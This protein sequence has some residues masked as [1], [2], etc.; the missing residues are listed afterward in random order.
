MTTAS[1]VITKPEGFCWHASV[2]LPLALRS[3]HG[4]MFSQT[5]YRYCDYVDTRLWYRSEWPAWESVVYRTPEMRP[6]Q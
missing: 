4:V 3:V 1:I 5:K 2:T 6:P